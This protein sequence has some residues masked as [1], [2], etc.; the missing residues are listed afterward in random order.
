MTPLTQKLFWSKLSNTAYEVYKNILTFP[1]AYILNSF[2]FFQW[3]QRVYD[4][5]GYRFS[6]EIPAEASCSISDFET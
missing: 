6:F 5:F 2:I 1:I 3:F 4:I